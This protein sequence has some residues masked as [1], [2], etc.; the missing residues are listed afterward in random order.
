MKKTISYLLLSLMLCTV[1]GVTAF[2][3][4]RSYVF[5][6]GQ[7]FVVAG[8]NVKAGTYKI[9]YNDKTGELTFADKKT[10]EIVAKAKTTIQA[11]N[12]KS[13]F[14]DVKFVENV[15]TGVMFAGD[16]QEIVVEGSSQITTN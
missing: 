5:T 16:K 11:Q 12:N 15:V 2:A 9:T 6:F 13:V 10:K 7:D 3:K 1:M 4:E 8:T 14:F